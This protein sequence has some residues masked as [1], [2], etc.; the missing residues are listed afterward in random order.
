MNTPDGPLSLSHFV[1]IPSQPGPSTY[2]LDDDNPFIA[3]HGKKPKSQVPQALPSSCSVV[4]LVH[5]PTP[6][7]TQRTLPQIYVARR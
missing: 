7:T 5:P 6:L 3:C 2:T 1:A 4:R